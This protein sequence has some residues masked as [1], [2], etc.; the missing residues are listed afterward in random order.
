MGVAASRKLLELCQEGQESGQDDVVELLSKKW[1]VDVNAVTEDGNSPLHWAAYHGMHRIVGLLVRKGA[2]VNSYNQLGS[3]P[4]MIAC[5]YGRA[6]VV[7][8]L[9]QHKADVHAQSPPSYCGGS[10]DAASGGSGGGD[11]GLPA[12]G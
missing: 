10:A 3:T 11:P 9:I 6:K 7:R 4:L 12:G 2:S 8:A 1:F 5:R